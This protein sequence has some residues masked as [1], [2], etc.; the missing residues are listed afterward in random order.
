MVSVGNLLSLIRVCLTHKNASGRVFLVSD[1]HDVSTSDLIEACARLMGRNVYL[2]YAPPWLLH[3]VCR[4]IRKPQVSERLLG[5]LQ[6][7]IQE[8]ID[9]LGWI[10][11]LTF[12]EGLGFMGN[13]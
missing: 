9:L 5:S 3:G 12:H 10:P 7:D 6:V 1:N 13:N 4:M 2:F 11:P 8:T